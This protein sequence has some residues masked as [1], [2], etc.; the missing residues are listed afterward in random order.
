MKNLKHESAEELKTK[1]PSVKITPIGDTGDWDKGVEKGTKM[2]RQ[3]K[4]H[5]DPKKLTPEQMADAAMSQL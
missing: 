1:Y 5:L 2:L 3:K 4:L